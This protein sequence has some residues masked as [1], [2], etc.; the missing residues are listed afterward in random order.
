LTS[1]VDL[2]HAQGRPVDRQWGF[3]DGCENCMACGGK[4]VRV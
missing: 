4:L 2:R 1:R 3:R